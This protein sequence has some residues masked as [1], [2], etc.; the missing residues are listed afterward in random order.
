MSIGHTNTPAEQRASRSSADRKRIQA[1]RAEPPGLAKG[2]GA[3]RRVFGAALGQWDALLTASSTVGPSVAPILLFYALA[4]AGRAVCAAGIRGQTWRPR[5]HGLAIG[6][7]YPTIGDTPITP[8]GRSNSA[9][10]L[11]C[12]AIDGVALDAPTTLGAL[13]ASD[14]N[15]SCTAELGEQ[16]R[17][18][19]DGV[20]DLAP[21]ARW[22]SLLLALSSLA[23][24][25]PERWGD[26]LSRDGSPSAIPIEDALDVA[27]DALPTLLAGAL[28]DL[29]ALEQQRR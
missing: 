23:R 29:K 4:Q 19:A 27:R 11:F 10:R 28:A 17:Q 18:C 26:A 24:Y 25:H 1:F 7:P 20:S 12:S 3:R 5:T 8:D 13:W 21:L 14:A 16:H 9:F 6:E 22:W 15:L 2:S